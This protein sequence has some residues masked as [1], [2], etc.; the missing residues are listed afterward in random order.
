MF[1][2]VAYKLTFALKSLIG[3]GFR[4]EIESNLILIA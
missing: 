1:D 3:F 2:T 4:C